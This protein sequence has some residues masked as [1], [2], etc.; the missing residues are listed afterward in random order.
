MYSSVLL[1]Y[2]SVYET[3]IN[4]LKFVVD[5]NEYL[6]ILVQFGFYSYI[7]KS[8]KIYSANSFYTDH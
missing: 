6:N 4:I 3:N 7:N 2:Q 1:R 8:T 5:V